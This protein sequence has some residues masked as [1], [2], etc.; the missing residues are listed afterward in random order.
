MAEIKIEKKA[1]VWPWLLIGGLLIIALIY[2]FGFRNNDQPEVVQTPPETIEVESGSVDQYVQFI[3]EGRTMGLDHNYTNG[4]LSKL[5]T[6][7]KAKAQQTGFDVEA[8]L[9]K[10]KEHSDQITNDPF[11]TTHANNIRKAADIL[12]DAMQNMQKAKYP[13]LTAQADEVRSA[14]NSINPDVL[15]LDQRDAVKVFFQKSADLLQNMN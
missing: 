3:N 5:T 14:A 7:I 12:T 1:P 9:E 11:E 15:T 10:V 8:D 13:N 2:Y 6:A 4:A